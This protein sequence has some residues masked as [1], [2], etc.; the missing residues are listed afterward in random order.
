MNLS[1]SLNLSVESM[2]IPLPPGDDT[3]YA[4]GSSFRILMHFVVVK[5]AEAIARVGILI[6]HL[7]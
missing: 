4:I 1:G 6:I 5:G 2:C 3:S 7:P